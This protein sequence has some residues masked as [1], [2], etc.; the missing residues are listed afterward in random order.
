MADLSKS[1]IFTRLYL[2]LEVTGFL[3]HLLGFCTPYWRSLHFKYTEDVIKDIDIVI[4]G[5]DEGIWRRCVNGICS[6]INIVG[7]DWLQV[8]RV[9]EIIA[10]GASL[11]ATFLVI[12]NLSVSRFSDSKR[13]YFLALLSC[14]VT[15]G[16]I[17]LSAIVYG[18]SVREG[19]T[20]SYGCVVI[21]GIFFMAS[22]VL[23]LT[24]YFTMRSKK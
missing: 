17:L 21:A 12:L 3:L 8:V 23:M 14:F 16:S 2:V 4:Q 13:I 1:D 11:F 20:W 22:G 18:A 19:I 5:F 24:N 10:L 6:D 15:A 7:R 9:F